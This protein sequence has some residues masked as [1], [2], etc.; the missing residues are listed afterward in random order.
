MLRVGDSEN[1]GL[2]KKQGGPVRLPLQLRFGCGTVRAVPVFRFRRFVCQS[3]NRKRWRQTGSRQSTPL[4]TIRTRYRNS[5]STPE[6]TQKCETRKRAEYGFREYGFKH[7]TQGVYWG[8]LSSG[9]RTQRVP[10]SLAFVCQSELTEFFAELTE[11]A[12][13]CPETQWGSVSSLLRN[14]TP[15]TVFRPF[16]RNP[17]EFSLKE[18][19]IWNF[20]IDPTSSIRTQTPFLRTQL[21]RHFSLGEEVFS[22]SGQLTARTGSCSGTQ[23]TLM[24]F[25]SIRSPIP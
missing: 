18:K 20:G 6:A 3:W 22:A 16:P 14:S 25:F 11:F 9:E 2:E 13:V 21:P 17:A 5:V 10:L 19:P 15:E 12:A 24:Y 23:R 8:S 1:E 7:R 4:S